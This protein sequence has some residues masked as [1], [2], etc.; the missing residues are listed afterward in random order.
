MR[1]PRPRYPTHVAT[2]VIALLAVGV[3]LLL[4]A[5]AQAHA[6]SQKTAVAQKALKIFTAEYK[7]QVAYSAAQMQ[8]NL[9]SAQTNLASTASSIDS[10]AQSNVVAA[11]ALVDELEDQYDAAGAL[12]IFKAALTANTALA[13]LS[14]P[15]AQHKNAVDDEAY[16]KRVL[17]I[18]TSADLA[19]WRSAGYAA[20]GEPA[21]T[22][23]FGVTVGLSL[24]SIDVAVSGSRSAI[25]TFEKL[26]NKANTETNAVF[27]TV[28]SD[29]A[30][31]AAN[32][33]I[34]A[35]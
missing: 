11:Q 29:W 31:W 12:G 28:S 25:K 9:N 8:A 27:N 10:L 14:L 6:V 2:T 23:E 1:R 24:P 3:A 32:F 18:N 35:Y 33:G 5:S 13:K 21:D 22:K 20:A 19:S 30:T 26:E 34:E 4:S 17:A 15:H 16:I 7:A